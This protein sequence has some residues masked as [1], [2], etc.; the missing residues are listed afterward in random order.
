MLAPAQ[1]PRR[2]LSHDAPRGQHRDPVGQVYCRAA[3]RTS[4][5]RWRAIACSRC[6]CIEVGLSSG[7]LWG[8]LQPAVS[9]ARRECDC[10]AVLPPVRSPARRAPWP[11]PHLGPADRAGGPHAMGAR[12]GASVGGYG[13]AA[14]F[15]ISPASHPIPR[16]TD[17]GQPGPGGRL[18][19]TVRRLAAVSRHPK[20]RA[21]WNVAAGRSLTRRCYTSMSWRYAGLTWPRRAAAAPPDASDRSRDA[22]DGAQSAAC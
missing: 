12:A 17:G 22:L 18:F 14:L 9:A 16:G 13:S 3:R 4:S 8:F 1:R 11:E 20:V 10:L 21:G 7:D 15:L 6:E 2:A 19:G 5:S